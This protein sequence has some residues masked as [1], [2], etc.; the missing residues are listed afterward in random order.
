[1]KNLLNIYYLDISRRINIIIPAYENIIYSYIAQRRWRRLCILVKLYP[2]FQLA[3][4][5]QIY[6]NI[7]F[8]T[9]TMYYPY[10]INLFRNLNN[11]FNIAIKKCRYCLR[12]DY[13][14][15]GDVDI[16][17]VCCDCNLN[18]YR[19]NICYDVIKSGY[20]CDNCDYKSRLC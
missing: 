5:C 3:K 4:N 6:L 2:H 20:Y 10:S 16:N 15:C 19:C 14:Y 8:K 1:M 12:I 11:G 9:G 7:Y 13:S 17:E 18:V